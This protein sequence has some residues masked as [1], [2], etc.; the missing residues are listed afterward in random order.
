[1]LQ[2]FSIVIK[3]EIYITLFTTLS[4]FV[5]AEI[6]K[7]KRESAFCWLSILCGLAIGAKLT[8]LPLLS[9]LI[10]AG[11]VLSGQHQNR[12]TEF[13]RISLKGL[14]IS[15]GIFVL[16]TPGM[17]IHP[18][19]YF[20][21][22][23]SDFRYRAAFDKHVYEN[24]LAVLYS[25]WNSVKDT[26]F[27]FYVNDIV[28]YCLLV[29]SIIWFSLKNRTL[30][31]GIF[32]FMLCSLWANI[33]LN[34]LYP[35]LFIH[36]NPVIYFVFLFPLA[37]TL[38]SIGKKISTGA[39]M[40]RSLNFCVIDRVV[41]S[42]IIIV[43]CIQN[44]SKLANF[45][46]SPAM[47][48]VVKDDSRLKLLQYVKDNQNINFAMFNY[49]YYSMPGEFDSLKN[50]NYFDNIDELDALLKENKNRFLIYFQEDGGYCGFIETR[51]IENYKS[52]RKYFEQYPRVFEIEGNSGNI[53][54]AQGPQ[55]NPLIVI[56][57][58]GS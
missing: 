7:K 53:F 36:L 34:E 26:I 27:S 21:F 40:F 52:C 9:L 20:K 51:A 35:R 15:L 24:N 10:F 50:V 57:N 5:F 54:G 1:M 45:L 49:H 22:L 46:I 3:P 2:M 13:I 48:S 29:Y 14:K 47:A 31:F 8:C 23:F 19:H 6:V 44:G 12:V 28:F 39:G 41:L 30:F 33:N 38:T 58:T 11:Y 32:I 18:H 16:A 55:T 56:R 17:I 43:F 42:G 25:W 37:A 4:I